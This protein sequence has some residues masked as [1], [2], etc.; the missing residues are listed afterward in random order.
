[1]GQMFSSAPSVPKTFARRKDGSFSP[2]QILYILDAFMLA[3]RDFQGKCGLNKYVVCAKKR[4]ALKRAF[5]I[6]SLDA[7][8]ARNMQWVAYKIGG[9]SYRTNLDA[10]QSKML[11]A[12]NDRKQK[13]NGRAKDVC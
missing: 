3:T 8:V 12:I 10:D 5:G 1:M 4:P 6:G 13:F 11:S 7:C 9:K 2:D